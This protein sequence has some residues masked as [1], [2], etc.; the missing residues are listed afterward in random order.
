MALFRRAR[1]KLGRTTQA[2]IERLR[3]YRGGVD[4][5]A[6][7]V[8]KVL[9]VYSD[10]ATCNIQSWSGAKKYNVPV[11]TKGGLI[12]D[13]V[14]G[15]LDLPA[16]G[17]YVIVSFIRG[18]ESQ[19]IIE[20]TILP[21][22]NNL[23]GSGQTAVNSSSKQFTL[24]LLEEGKEDHYKKIF[25]SGT[26]IEVKEDGTIVL[27]VPSGTYITI[28][29]DSNN[30]I[31]EDQYGNKFTLNSSGV[32]IEDANGNDITMQSGK[33]TVNGNLEVLQ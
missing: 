33:V 2:G 31:V 22:L 27:E 16:V 10:R 24:K 13:E 8:A 17:D 20:G 9:S 28:D 6:S 26:T 18:K 30:I 29:E 7:N 19:P 5:V 32:L 14:Y 21:Y 25:K 4:V 11:R 23:F 3:K 15:E 1:G 12:D